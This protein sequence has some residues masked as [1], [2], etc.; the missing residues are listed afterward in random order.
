[1][2]H[3]N[4]S[5]FS[6]HS[7]R[8]FGLWRTHDDWFLVIMSRKFVSWFMMWLKKRVCIIS[9]QNWVYRQQIIDTIFVNLQNVKILMRDDD[10]HRFHHHH[11]QQSDCSCHPLQSD[12]G[13]MTLE[14]TSPTLS[15]NVTSP[16]SES[17]RST[18]DDG[19]RPNCQDGK[20]PRPSSR[21]ARTSCKR[22]QCSS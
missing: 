3:L 12:L 10:G 17:F 4:F 14:G 13:K 22:P 9:C 21:S 11:R 5:I 19:K 15:R 16:H 7:F 2:Y 6:W 20:N 1:M 18:W 8:I